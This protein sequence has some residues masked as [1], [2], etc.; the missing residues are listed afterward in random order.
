M[1]SSDG[2]YAISQE[3]ETISNCLKAMGLNFMA[4]KAIHP[5]TSQEL[6]DRFLNIIKKEARIAKRHDVLEQLY[7]AGLT[8]S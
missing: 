1:L 3:R 4:D 8:H 5:E 7:F 2:I 6:I